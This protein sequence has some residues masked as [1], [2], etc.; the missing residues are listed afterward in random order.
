MLDVPYLFSKSNINLQRMTKSKWRLGEVGKFY[1]L[2]VFKTH[3]HNQS[4]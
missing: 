2:N 3:V 4:Y 1:H